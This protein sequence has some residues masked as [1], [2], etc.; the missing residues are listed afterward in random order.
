LAALRAS[1]DEG[2][3]AELRGRLAAAAAGDDK[4]IP[5]LITCVEN[6]MTLGEICATLRQAWGEYREQQ[7]W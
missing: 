3:V 6:D 1:R 7:S 4:L 2:R 5:L